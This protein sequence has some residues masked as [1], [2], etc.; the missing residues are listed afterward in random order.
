MERIRQESEKSPDPP[1]FKKF[2][3]RNPFFREEGKVIGKKQQ[4][5]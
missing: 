3:G 2:L 4:K 1:A 5:R